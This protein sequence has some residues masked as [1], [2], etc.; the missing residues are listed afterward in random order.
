MRLSAKHC[1]LSALLWVLPIH[2][3]DLPEPPPFWKYE[4]PPAVPTR[5]PFEPEMIDI[6]AGKFTMG[7]K[8]GRDAVEGGCDSDEKPAHEVSISAFQIAKTEVTFE[9][10]D[11]CEK[12]KACPHAQDEGWGR[13]KRPVINVSWDDITQKYIPWLNGK[14]GKHYRL[15]TEAEWEYAARGG[16]DTAYPWGN[17]ASHE[18]ANYGK[19]EC[20]GG[21]ASGKDE[22][23]NTSPVGSFAAN[24]FGL[25]D[26]HGNVYE[27]V[28]DW[29]GSYAAEPQQDPQGE[30]TGTFRVLRGGSWHNSP[31]LVRSAYRD[32]HAPGYRGNRVGFRVAQGQ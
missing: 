8:A 27:W 5:Q 12:A 4:P 29:D 15:P 20:C 1:L 13:G 6:P 16:T 24:P 28:S 21:L 17:K 26:M 2:A 31:W 23:V 11:E 30:N 7:C 9:Q 10:W 32:L 14:T 19:D 18:F 3:A 25:S 22:W